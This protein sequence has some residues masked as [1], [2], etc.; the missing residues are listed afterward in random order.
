MEIQRVLIPS[1]ELLGVGVDIFEQSFGDV[2][3]PPSLQI[4]QEDAC[5]EVC[6]PG[7]QAQPSRV[8]ARHR[9]LNCGM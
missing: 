3:I 6:R 2:L 8:P 7:R 9:I 4:H 5:I 1:K